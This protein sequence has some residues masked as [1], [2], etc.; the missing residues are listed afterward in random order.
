MTREH[1]EPLTADVHPDEVEN[2]RAAASDLDAG[3]AAL[4]SP[5]KPKRRKAKR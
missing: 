1:G 2:Y 3:D 5:A 4:A